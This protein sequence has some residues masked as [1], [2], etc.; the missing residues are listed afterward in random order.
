MN[1]STTSLDF[2]PQTVEN[3]QRPISRGIKCVDLLY[4][5]NSCQWGNTDHKDSETKS[6]RTD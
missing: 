5:D 6:H 4:K 1:S 2:V 3:Y